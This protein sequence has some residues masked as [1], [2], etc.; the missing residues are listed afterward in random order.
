VLFAAHAY[1]GESTEN[2]GKYYRNNVVHSIALLDALLAA[3]VRLVVFSSSCSVYGLQ[4]RMPITEDSSLDPLSPYA[5]S[6]VFM[7]WIL[8][9]YGKA[10]GLRYVSLRYFNAAGADPEGE[11]GECHDPEAH[12]IPLAILSA[13]GKGELQV[14]GE[15]YP[16]PDGTCIRD[17]VHV[18]DL[19]EAHVLAL[20][21]LYNGGA[22][23]TVNLGTGTG[24]SVREVIQT[25][26]Q[27]GGQPVSYRTAPRRPGDAPILVADRAKALR[28]LGW[29]PRLSELNTIVETAWKWHSR[30]AISGPPGSSR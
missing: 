18:S 8:H 16:T 20:E 3:R 1:V 23:E 9:W 28:V 14:F 27:V 26:H 29:K 7:E 10:H 24:N 6:K 12:L 15:D 13:L 19:A 11:L 17:Y 30:Y 4:T 2:P 25:V 21:H 22:S 5:E